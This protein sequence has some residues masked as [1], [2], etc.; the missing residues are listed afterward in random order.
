[1][2]VPSV[3]CLSGNQTSIGVH[4]VAKACF[5]SAATRALE[6]FFKAVILA[7]SGFW[8]GCCGSGAMC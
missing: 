5:R 3:L 7:I 8:T 6:E 2:L 1:M 4:P